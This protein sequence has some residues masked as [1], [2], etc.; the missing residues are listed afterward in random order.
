MGA[1]KR[2][3]QD[4]SGQG[5][6]AALAR[7]FR[8]GTGRFLATMAVVLLAIVAVGYAWRRWGPAVLSVADSSLAVSKLSIS[9]QPR[10]IRINVKE[11]VFRDGSLAELKY[12]D[13]ELT[14]KVHRAFLMHAWVADVQR[15][16]K[17]PAGTI[18]VDLRYRRPVAWVELPGYGQSQRDSILPIDS[19]AVVL[20]PGE[21]LIN[22]EDLLRIFISDL[23]EFG[24]KGTPWGDS[25]LL[26]AAKLA[27]LLQDC[28][29][30]LGI[31]RIHGLSSVDPR[32]SEASVYE[33]VTVHEQRLTWGS[34]PG[35]EPPSEP[36]AADK[37]ERL[38][39]IGNDG[40]LSQATRHFDL[41]LPYTG[42]EIRR[43]A[44]RR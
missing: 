22:Q 2:S 11:Q 37:L 15:V 12:L 24:P 41:R 7:P 44:R 35:E 23:P 40:H 3:S 32:Q 27:S 38:K 1:R 9:K 16:T 36:K 43:T 18:D 14:C 19:Q 6:I 8:G 10:W 30:E 5:W 29:C 34:A 17:S 21:L 39:Q 28:W 13:E 20:E 26:G 42:R 4:S 31:F 33:L 25:R